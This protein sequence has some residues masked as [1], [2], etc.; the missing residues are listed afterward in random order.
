MTDNPRI[1]LAADELTA[2]ELLRLL[3][4]VGS[5]LYAVKIHN[6]Y[7][8]HGS[9]VIRWLKNYVHRVWVDAKLHDIPNTVA[10]RAKAL[11]NAG[12]DILTVHASGGIDM[13]NAAREHGPAE[14]YGVTVL[15]SLND[16]Q[17]LEIYCRFVEEEV[18]RLARL[19]NVTG[20]NGLVCSPNEL[21]PIRLDSGIR[22][23]I[24]LV[25]PGIRSAGA[26]AGDQQRIATP[27]LAIRNGA[28][29]L[30]IGR[31]ITQAQNPLLALEQIEVEI[32]TAL[33]PKPQEG[34]Q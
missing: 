19:V 12:A 9:E 16:E 4:I 14:V 5:R 8:E 31:P 29:L 34:A 6:L 21:E 1:V 26:H 22:P 30:V 28:S 13:M 25:T 27:G 3:K 10:L 15:T 7:D 33:L 2:E 32:A 20:L 18:L 24:K 17:A 23:S 11:K